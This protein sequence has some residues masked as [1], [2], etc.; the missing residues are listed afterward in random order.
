MNVSPIGFVGLEAVYKNSSAGYR[1][2]QTDRQTHLSY[3]QSEH[4]S[5]DWRLPRNIRLKLLAWHKSIN[6]SLITLKDDKTENWCNNSWRA[7]REAYTYMMS[8][9]WHHDLY[10]QTL[11][12]ISRFS[13]ILSVLKIK[14]NLSK[15]PPYR[16]CVA[17][18]TTLENVSVLKA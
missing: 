1:P 18:Y 5:N 12:N 2:T 3:G 13:K 10:I 15:M 11:S 7:L 8:Q 4:S 9:K 17:P 14:D 6:Q 16:R